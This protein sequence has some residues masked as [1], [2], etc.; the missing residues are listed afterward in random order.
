M[1]EYYR[2]PKIKNVVIDY[3]SMDRYEDRCSKE[4]KADY[5]VSA[6][7]YNKAMELLAMAM[8]GIVPNG[9]YSDME[10]EVWSGFKTILYHEGV[11]DIYDR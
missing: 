4:H 7:G 5:G 10:V 8:E 11:K 2:N 1:A 6:I 9:T 3:N